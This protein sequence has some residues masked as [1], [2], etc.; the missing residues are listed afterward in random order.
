LI[1]TRNNTLIATV[2]V[3]AHPVN[4]WITPDGSNV[5]VADAGANSVF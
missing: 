1:N 5:Y 2:A 3:G 4:A